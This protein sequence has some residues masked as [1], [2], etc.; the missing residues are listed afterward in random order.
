MVIR[1]IRGQGFTKNRNKYTFAD[2][3]MTEM[4]NPDPKAILEKFNDSFASVTMNSFQ[5]P[6]VDY[7]A[8]TG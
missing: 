2:P 1:T 5:S 6:T 3:F 7:V 4:N 8:N